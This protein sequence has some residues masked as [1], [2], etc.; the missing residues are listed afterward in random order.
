MIN[1]DI[2]EKKKCGRL[3]FESAKVSLPEVG[4]FFLLGDNGSGKTT[5]LS[6]LSGRDTDF[7]GSISYCGE[8]LDGKALSY[9]AEEMVCYCPQDPLIFNN[10]SVLNNIVFP[11]AK[12]DKGH[13][14]AI[15]DELGIGNLA[16]SYAGDLSSGEQ[17]RVAVGRCLYSSRPILLL[18]E[19][20]SFLDEAN[21]ERI[22]DCLRKYSEDHLVILSTNE[23]IP[24]SCSGCPIL[25]IEGKR[26][27]A[28][29]AAD[30]VG[31][32][33][34]TKPKPQKIKANDRAGI[35]RAFMERPIIN[36]LTV[37]LGALFF[38]CSV[39]FASML[40]T[41]SGNA[42]SCF[43]ESSAWPGYSAISYCQN[44]D[45]FLG[46]EGC[47][48]ELS[49][50]AKQTF[51]DIDGIDSSSLSAP[52]MLMI[53][54][55]S[56][57]SKPLSE[58]TLD[59]SLGD[60]PDEIGEAAVPSAVYESICELFGI[61][62]PYSENGFRQASSLPMVPYSGGSG[63]FTICGVFKSDPRPH[64]G[65]YLRSEENVQYDALSAFCFRSASAIVF[66]GI[67]GLQGS[68]LCINC[69]ETRELALRQR[70]FW[71]EGSFLSFGHDLREEKPICE[72]PA[73]NFSFFV[74]S[75][76]LYALFL[77]LMVASYS[78]YSFRRFLLLRLSGAS[79]EALSRPR[80]L[81]FSLMPI[82]SFAIGAIMGVIGVYVYQSVFL[83]SLLGYPTSFVRIG[84]D[85]I[86]LPA[87]FSLL[88]GAAAALA[89]RWGLFRKNLS[90]VLQ[91]A[92][93]K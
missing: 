11:F 88:I 44:A 69:P 55:K 21:S 66:S 14:L 18:D 42:F 8:R 3:V 23:R 6:M 71:S 90:K 1:I 47:P 12:K 48:D 92:R 33:S 81:L 9:Y 31:G 32:E 78:A 26:I 7:E 37:L 45:A 67:D 73:T 60:F 68:E 39:F 80:L 93:A 4:M 82:V 49:F 34:E 54:S 72:W 27:K 15:L 51:F 38:A 77:L 17:Q 57:D 40:T 2:F 86:L 50:K 30:D 63:A 64:I 84:A 46:L 62:E 36:S 43:G 35:V 22:I 74:C 59:F 89:L 5:L 65:E 58:E 16:K 56:Y 76:A 91:R 70:P 24:E 61:D 75:L 85:A 41:Y 20:V 83:S 53:D 13:A 10:D 25:T 28:Y 79:R 29:R 87:L 52:L 19:P